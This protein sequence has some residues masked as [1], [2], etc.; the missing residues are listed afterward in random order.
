MFKLRLFRAQPML[1]ITSRCDRGLCACV[2]GGVVL[3]AGGVVALP[4]C[5]L[6]AYAPHIAIAPSEIRSLDGLGVFWATSVRLFLS[7]ADLPLQPGEA[8]IE[9][10]GPAFGPTAR[11]SAMTGQDAVVWLGCAS[12]A[13]AK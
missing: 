9:A 7:A 13:M 3:F 4:L 5:A 1:V 12:M 11:V 2:W 10:S 6:L 8:I